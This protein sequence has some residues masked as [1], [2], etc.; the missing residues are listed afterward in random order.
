M[1]MS[2]RHSL[3]NETRL[4]KPKNKCLLAES[5]ECIVGKHLVLYVLVMYETFAFG[6]NE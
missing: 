6:F 2:S 1:V 5:K 3:L 4:K